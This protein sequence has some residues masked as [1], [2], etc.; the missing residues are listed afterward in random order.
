MLAARVIF[1]MRIKL[2]LNNEQESQLMLS[3]IFNARYVLSTKRGTC[4]MKS[5]PINIPPK[6]YIKS[7]SV[8]HVYFITLLPSRDGLFREYWIP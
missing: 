7:C 8:S 1:F 5:F 4:I 6:W 2:R 3:L